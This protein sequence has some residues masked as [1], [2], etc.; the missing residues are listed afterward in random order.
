MKSLSI[1]WFAWYLSGI[2][3]LIAVMTSVITYGPETE[4]FGMVLSLGFLGCSLLASILAEVL[5]RLPV[6]NWVHQSQ[7]VRIGLAVLAVAVTL[8]LVLAG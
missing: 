3:F 8:L 7:P 2:L 1:V 6:D 4:W 5:G